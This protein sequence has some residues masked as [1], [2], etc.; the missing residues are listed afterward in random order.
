MAQTGP[1]ATML[2]R[3]QTWMPVHCINGLQQE[4]LRCT[5]MGWGDGREREAEWFEEE[6]QAERKTQAWST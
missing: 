4:P 5:T 1:P 6:R 3:Q 2:S